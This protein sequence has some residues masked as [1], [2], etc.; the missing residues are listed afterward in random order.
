MLLIQVELRQLSFKI[1]LK[2]LKQQLLQ[3]IAGMKAEELMQEMTTLIEMMKNGYAIHF[4]IPNLNQF[5][6]EM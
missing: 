4:M 6:K 1:Y 5:Q 3:H 2:L